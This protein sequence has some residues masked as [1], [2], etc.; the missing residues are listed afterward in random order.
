M[1]KIHTRSRQAGTCLAALAVLLASAGAQATPI[2]RWVDKAGRTQ[3]ASTVPDAYQA[4]ATCKDSQQYELTAPQRQAAEQRAAADKA[5]AGV[6]ASKRAAS[7]AT[8]QRLPATAI[9][10]PVIKRPAER[11]T[12]ATDCPTRWRLY[13]E[14]A[15]CFGPYRTT[16][17]ATR[18]E[19]FDACN[20]IESPEPVCGLRSDP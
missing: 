19:G 20:V 3:I 6:A 8:A 10:T 9:P 2:C 17:G 7:A 12:E 18:V 13:D 16:R 5:R 11:I 1:N 4:V 15:D 14:S